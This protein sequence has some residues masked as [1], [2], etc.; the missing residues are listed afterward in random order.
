MG[1][2]IGTAN[3]LVEPPHG[4]TVPGPVRVF[5]DAAIGADG[6]IL[7]HSDDEWTEL[8]SGAA[9]ICA[10]DAPGGLLVGAESAHLFRVGPT[11]DLVAV[12]GFERCPGREEW[13]TPWGGPPDVRSVACTL[14]NVLL[15][16]VHVGGIPRSL[17]GGRTWEPTI[18]IHADVH[19]VRA[20]LERED[21]VVAAAAVGCCV[22]HDAGATW[23]V[24]D[25][26]LHATY[27]RAIAVSGDMILISASEGP[28]GRQSAIYR[29]SVEGDGPFVRVTEWIDGNIDTHALDL[30]GDHGVFGTRDG[31]VWESWDG[32]VTWEQ[33]QEDLPSITSVSLT[34]PVGGSAVRDPA[35][36]RGLGRA[37]G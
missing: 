30:R 19:Q 7:W 6:R 28:R 15:A 5:G 12:P 27:C 23:S 16:N 34:E 10:V 25:D 21:L 32:G 17:D 20:S 9:L 3:G 26:G 33:T 14:D 18:D 35:V 37:D 31:T 1:V 36:N 2:R 29:G 11:G 8:A 13:Y 22:S 4:V 24:R